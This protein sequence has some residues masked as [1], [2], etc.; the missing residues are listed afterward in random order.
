MCFLAKIEIWAAPDI[1][2]PDPE[3][4]DSDAGSS[5]QDAI[6]SLE[7]LSAEEAAE[8]EAQVFEQHRFVLCPQCRSN[9]HR[10]LKA[11]S[12]SNAP[13]EDP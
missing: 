10:D 3:S 5:L 8:A 12:T 11:F 1:A 9:L 6:D 4:L 2:I 7:R 13:R